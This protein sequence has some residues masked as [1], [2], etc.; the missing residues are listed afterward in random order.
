MREPR[1]FRASRVVRRTDPELSG[2]LST[3]FADPVTSLLGPSG[4]FRLDSRF[5]IVLGHRACDGCLLIET[6]ALAM[7]LHTCVLQV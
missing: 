3:K 1:P 7:P 2:S 5:W 6:G 4:L